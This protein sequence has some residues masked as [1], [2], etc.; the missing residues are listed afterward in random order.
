[1]ALAVILALAYKTVFGHLPSV[2]VVLGAIVVLWLA[3][4]R[5]EEK[6]LSDHRKLL[7]FWRFTLGQPLRLFPLGEE[8][9]KLAGWAESEMLGPLA[10]EV[11]AAFDER[12]VNRKASQGLQIEIEHRQERMVSNPSE[13]ETYRRELKELQAFRN[14]VSRHIWEADQRG[15]KLRKKYL[16]MWDF[17]TKAEPAGIRVLANPPFRFRDPDSFRRHVMETTPFRAGG[18]AHVPYAGA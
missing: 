14:N 6:I 12:E 17:F 15:E 9:Q 11:S 13:I 16:A 8:R 7:D 18:S 3:V 10:I 5:Q 4:R 2:L 1:M